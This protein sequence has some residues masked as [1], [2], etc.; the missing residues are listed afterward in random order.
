MAEGCGTPPLFRVLIGGTPC[1]SR[2]GRGRAS[3]RQPRGAPRPS[4]QTGR[5]RRWRVRRRRLRAPLRP[6]RPL[7]ALAAAGAVSRARTDMRYGPAGRGQRGARAASGGGSAQAGGGAAPL[8]PLTVPGRVAVP[9]PAP[10]PRLPRRAV[11]DAAPLAG[12]G[13]L[14]LCPDR[15]AVPPPRGSLRWDHLGPAARARCALSR[16][17]GRALSRECL[18]LERHSLERQPLAVPS[19]RARQRAPRNGG[20][21]VGM[22]SGRQGKEAGPWMGLC[23]RVCLCLGEQARLWMIFPFVLVHL[24]LYLG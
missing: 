22:L 6:L 19:L 4:P 21:N 7:G 23:P 1:P 16:G 5:G 2:G 9:G 8:Q 11:S 13:C 3:V 20:M 24:L 17:G 12:A 15:V 14:P 10:R 18:S